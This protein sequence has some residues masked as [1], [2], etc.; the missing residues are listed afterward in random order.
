[1]RNMDESGKSGEVVTHDARQQYIHLLI[2]QANKTIS[3][4]EMRDY[5]L[6]L[7]YLKGW[8]RW[9]SWF[10]NDPKLKGEL[11]K[12]DVEKEKASKKI[13][14]LIQRGKKNKNTYHY[15]KDV[16]K[17]LETMIDILVDCMDK[18]Q[19]LVPKGEAKDHYNMVGS[20]VYE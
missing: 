8:R 19:A 13:E 3:S 11:Q 2:A 4:F 5:E 9:T 16:E 18:K 14:N 10:K 15:E 20:E 12:F 1:M 6:T 7:Q 17:V